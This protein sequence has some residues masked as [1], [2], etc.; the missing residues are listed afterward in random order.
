MLSIDVVVLAIPNSMV[1]AELFVELGVPH[2]I[3]FNFSEEF[4]Q[5]SSYYDSHINAPYE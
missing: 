3:C 4:M 1:L 5:T 2:V